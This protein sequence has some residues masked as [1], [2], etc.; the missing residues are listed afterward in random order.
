[1]RLI[2]LLPVLMGACLTAQAEMVENRINKTFEVARGGVLTMEVDRGSIDVRTADQSQIVVEVFRK[3]DAKSPSKAEEVFKDHHITFD[4]KGNSL[5]IKAESTG[6]AKKAERWGHGGLQVQYRLVVPSAFN[7]DVHTAGGGIGIAAIKGDVKAHTAGGG[8]NVGAVD[9]P[10]KA[11]TS[12]G[13]IEVKSATGLID[14]ET[15][16]GSVRV[17]SAPAGGRLHS[18]GGGLFLGG[19]SGKLVLETAGGSIDLTAQNAE[20][21]AHTSGGGIKAE[22]RA[23]LAGDCQIRT[24]AGGVELKLDDEIAANINAETSA[25]SVHTDLPVTVKGEAGS[26]RLQGTINGGG[27]KLSVVTS[28]GHI[29]IR[30]R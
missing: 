24:S 30:K 1:M 3:C 13:G 17:G 14:A 10:V 8:I 7:L 15:A 21:V 2:Y 6:A 22:L 27:P 5:S 12:G 25:G 23:P 9:G 19:G 26:G 18:S 29:A 28:A 16:G 20:V 4:H 11:H